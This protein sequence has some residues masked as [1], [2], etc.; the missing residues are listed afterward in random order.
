MAALI[1]DGDD[2][3]SA[4]IQQVMRCLVEDRDLFLG[5]RNLLKTYLKIEHC[6][7]QPDHW[8]NKDAK[9]WLIKPRVRPESQ[10]PVGKLG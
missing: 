6:M 9:S 5:V 7:Y 2:A 4:P 10:P 1:E 8:A 3:V